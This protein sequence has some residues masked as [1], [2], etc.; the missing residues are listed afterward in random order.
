MHMS[1][2]LNGYK[3]GV[4][5][6]KKVNIINVNYVKAAVRDIVKYQYIPKRCADLML[7]EKYCFYKHFKTNFAIEKY[8]T[9]LLNNM[10]KFRICNTRLPIEQGRP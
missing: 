1:C 9:C 6:V 5:N 2:D 3:T 8:L 4:S 10:R 7:S